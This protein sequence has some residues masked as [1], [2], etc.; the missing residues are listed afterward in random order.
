MLPA[1]MIIDPPSPSVTSVGATLDIP[2]V[3]ASFSSGGFSN[4]FAQPAYQA[5]A[6]AGFL[7]DQ[8]SGNAGLFNPRGRAYPDVSALGAQIQV[9]VSGSVLSV[10]GTSASAPIFAACISLI[11]DALLTN[12]KSPMG[13]LNNFLYSSAA[14]TFTDIVSGQ[15]HF[16]C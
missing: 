14:S 8:G 12:G 13:F 1:S 3:A 16:N 11:N 10:L 9:I 5:T 2:E 4:L 15:S 6:V 7:A